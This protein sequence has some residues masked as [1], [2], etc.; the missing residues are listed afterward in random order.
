MADSEPRAPAA[1]V[2]QVIQSYGG[3]GF[4][5]AGQRHEGSLILYPRRAEPWLVAAGS[6][7]SLE[8]VKGLL[9]RDNAAA[10]LLVGCGPL[11]PPK[12]IAA[13][14]RASGAGLEWMTTAAA[15]R[16][17]NLLLVDERA[18]IAALIAVE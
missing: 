11:A 3:G 5:V 18:V 1:G 12:D 16:T 2:P 17:W 8:S 10:M 7:I 9:A 6:D 14:V 15:C 13:A 4:R